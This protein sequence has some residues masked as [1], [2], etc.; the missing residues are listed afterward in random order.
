[1]EAFKRRRSMLDYRI[2]QLSKGSSEGSG[3]IPVVLDKPKDN[4]GSLSSS[5]SLSDNEVQEKLGMLC[6]QNWRDLPRDIPL[7]S[8]EVLRYDTKGVKV[9]MGNNAD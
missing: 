6:C 8:V 2:Q 5:F 3:I 7:D 1:M 4:S 9:R